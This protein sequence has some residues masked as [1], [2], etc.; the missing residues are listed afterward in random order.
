MRALVIGASGQV[1]SALVASL[2]E[3]GHDVVAAARTPQSDILR[4]DL[5]DTVATAR[6]I[7]ESEADW[8]FCPAGLTH[9]DY[10]EEHRDEAMRVNRDAPALAARAAA[11]HGSGFVYYSSEYVFDGADGPYAESDWTH[12]ISVYGESKLAGERVVQEGNPRAVIVRTTVVYG[13][14]PQ[15]KNFVYQLVKR[16]R[17]GE[18]MRVPGDQRSSPTYNADL[19]SAS[20][21][22]AERGRVGIFHV[23][24]PAILDRFAFA[25]LVCDV[26][27]LDPRLLEAVTTAELDQRAR[28]PLQAGLRI[29]RVRALV[30][31][32]LRAPAEGLRAMR[33]ALV[34]VDTP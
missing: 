16:A 6:L 32:P 24:G 5:L 8:V 4:L 2:H 23:A 25:R 12:P 26:F 28:R 1:G 17:N 9:V 20:V 22:L 33:E 14:E 13:P 31:A 11:R 21:E 7:G 18:R 10:C 34:V 19:A 29:D 3:R 15:G 30:D 27:G